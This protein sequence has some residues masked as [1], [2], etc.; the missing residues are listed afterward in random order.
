[1]MEFAP[2]VFLLSVSGCY[3]L[4]KRLRHQLYTVVSAVDDIPN[5]REALPDAEKWD[6]TAV[7]CGGRYFSGVPP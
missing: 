3:L 2:A 1:M 6:G 7:I 5:L 4:A